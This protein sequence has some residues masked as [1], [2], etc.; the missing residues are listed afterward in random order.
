MSMALV[1]LRVPGIIIR[2]PAC[3]TKTYPHFF[4]DLERLRG[5]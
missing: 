5:A 3:V 2:N 4:N 1:G